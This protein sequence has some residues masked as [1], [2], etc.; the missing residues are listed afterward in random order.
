MDNGN[1]KKLI[2][3]LICV[4]MS[5]GLWLYVTNVENPTRKSDIKDVPVELIN[6]DSLSSSNL[7]LLSNQKFTV[8]LKIEGPAN[9]IYSLNKNEF[10]LKADI[11][12]YALK[13]GDNNI[14]VQVVNYPQGIYIK[15]DGVLAVKVRID[16]LL[17][18]EVKV[19]SKVKVTYKEGFAQRGIS[20]KPQNVMVKGPAS[21]VERV[22]S[23]ALVGE[24]KDIDK[25]IE[26]NFPIKAF[27]KENNEIEG[28]SLSEAEGKLNIQVVK[29]KEVS[30]KP[31]YIGTLKDGLS[32][33]SIELS[34]NKI[35]ILGDMNE[36]DKISFIEL[37]A[38]DLSKISASKEFNLKIQVPNGIT[39][40]NSDEYVNVK[41]K[42]KSAETTIKELKNIKID[43]IGQDETKYKYEMPNVASVVLAGTE[44]NLAAISDINI[45]LEADLSSLIEGEHTVELKALLVNTDKNVTIKSNSGPIVVKVS[46]K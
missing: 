30:I 37:E 39:I 23:V 46:I 24:K 43:Y 11:G 1:E 36:I 5:F 44:V 20:V 33:D 10:K 27:D 14:P 18:K 9:I 2:V 13:K 45:K 38:I 3:K 15:N 31:T 40:A 16:D 42:I 12:A 35:N 22:N 7:A 6:V 29:G 34:K 25:D 19:E 32:I 8:D 21:E 4:L 28:L 17:E 41:L 26:E